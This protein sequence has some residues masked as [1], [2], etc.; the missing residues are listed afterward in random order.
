MAHGEPN[1]RHDRLQSR[2]AL[3][4]EATNLSSILLCCPLYH[5]ITQVLAVP[6]PSCMQQ[7]DASA[8]TMKMRRECNTIIYVGLEKYG[9]AYK[10]RAGDSAEPICAGPV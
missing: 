6:I 3:P 2:A 1:P 10:W 8:T 5:H 9:F 7:S 4:G